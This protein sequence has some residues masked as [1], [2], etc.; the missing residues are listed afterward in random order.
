MLRV[1]FYL[2]LTFFIFVTGTTAALVWWLMPQLPDTKGLRDVQLQIPLTVYT[3][4]GSLIAEFGEMRRK[5]V[6][7]EEVPLVVKQAFLAAEDD[8]FYE[9]P[10]AV[11]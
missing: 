10:M 4:D 5:P 3:T 6:A 8:R 11:S 9:H 7:I 1:S 2:L